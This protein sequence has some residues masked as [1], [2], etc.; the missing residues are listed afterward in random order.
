MSKDVKQNGDVEATNPGRFRRAV[1]YWDEL[2]PRML[3]DVADRDR[4]G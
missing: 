2:L 3:G 4:V 1:V